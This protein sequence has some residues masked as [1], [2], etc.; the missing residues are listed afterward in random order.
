MEDHLLKMRPDGTLVLV[1]TGPTRKKECA[2]SC[3]AALIIFAVAV[4]AFVCLAKYLGGVSGAIAA[5]LLGVGIAPLAGFVT[6]VILINRRTVEVPPPL[7]KQVVELALHAHPEAPKSTKF[8][9]VPA[10]HAALVKDLVAAYRT[11]TKAAT[12]ARDAKGRH[13]SAQGGLRAGTTSRRV[14]GERREAWRAAEGGRDRAGRS[15][16]EVQER[17]KEVLDS[18]PLNEEAQAV[19]QESW[20]RHVKAHGGYH[21]DPLA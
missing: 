19:W 2:L 10:E 20:K 12:R 21:Q 1:P 7:R 4:A 6:A 18:A 14:A 8:V 13:V 11:R 17:V 9:T 15:L 3:V 16:N 5:S